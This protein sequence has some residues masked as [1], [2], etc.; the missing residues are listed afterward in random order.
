MGLDLLD[1]ALNYSQHKHNLA[2][3]LQLHALNYQQFVNKG[4]DL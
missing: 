1:I 3:D 4:M 2:Y